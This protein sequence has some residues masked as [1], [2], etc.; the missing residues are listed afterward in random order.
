MPAICLDDIDVTA[1]LAR[2]PTRP[3]DHAVE[4]QALVELSQH[5]AETPH[6][7]LQALVDVALRICRAGS[8]GISILEEEDGESIF[9]WR[10][11]AGAFAPYLGGAMPG[12]FSPCAT[13]LDRNAAQLMANPERYYPYIASISPYVT[14]ALLVP[15]HRGGA[16]IGTVWVL[17]HEDNQRFDAED[18][19]LLT[20]I[21][22]FASAAV[23][24][25]A[26][27]QANGA[28]NDELR[29]ARARLELALSAG[30]IATWTWDI[31][32]DCVVAD[33]SLKRF[34]TTS[35]PDAAFHSIEHY[36]SAIHPADRERVRAQVWQAV[37]T[38][39]DLHSEY[40]I[41]QTDGRVLSLDVRGR[42]E[43]NAAGKATFM[44]GVT[45]DVTEQRE[46][47]DKL[48]T[49][50]KFSRSIVESSSDCVKVFDLDGRLLT[51]NANG[52][53]LMEV[54]DVSLFVSRRWQDCWPE[55]SRSMIEAAIEAATHGRATS[56][57]GFC[58][59]AKGAE[60]WWD[61]AVTPIVNA[62]GEVERILAV[63][64]D[65]TAIKRTEALLSSQTLALKQADQRK[66]DFLAMLAHELRN[67]LTAISYAHT[68]MEAS[69]E[70]THLEHCKETIGRQTKHLSRLI[71]DLLDVSRITLGKTELRCE[72]IN[73]GPLLE[74]A[75]HTVSP[76]VAQRKHTIDVTIDS[77]ELWVNADP[78]RLE[79]IVV[80]LLHN[81]AKYSE[82]CGHIWLSAG[83]ESGQ[84]VIRVKDEG[85]G[86]LPEKL[87]EMFELFAQADRSSARS[88]GGLG[89]GLTLAKRLVEMHDGAIA[90]H[91]DGSGKG[92]EFTIRL[93][94]ASRPSAPT[95][96]RNTADGPAKTACILVVDD[97]ADTAVTMARIL[98]RSGHQVVTAQ[99]GPEAIEAADEHQPDVILLDIGLPGMD[100]YEIVKRL[101]QKESTTKALIIAVTGYSQDG[102]PSRTR[103]A[104]F[105]HHLVK[106]IDLDHLKSLLERSP[107]G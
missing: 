99:S 43:R 80:N 89:I 93:P 61:V 53:R 62:D 21:S 6:T 17:L 36:L 72:L 95:S 47:A 27:L 103:V 23:Q 75:V 44:H 82:D 97:N 52:C 2:R 16:P 1:E 51:M 12:H 66:N 4:C 57:Q 74:S 49:S 60:K 88:A 76:L 77:D 42:I 106:P 79:Q 59:T 13:V 67:P 87:P 38:L 91:S 33:A 39:T 100:G 84:I 3:P 86:I 29:D 25:L 56:F 7:L 19:R 55:Q 26:N 92:S 24:M 63:L 71:D 101:R 28:A 104:G 35:S 90:A 48:I 50:E 54:D 70:P 83:R 11:T 8:A 46:A 85:V 20:S 32:D 5:L 41:V 31:I 102:D 68:L 105:D 40:R 30:E 15:F 9:R 14:E 73:A 45:V 22:K 10:A 81:A 78:T 18:A 96:L 107:R 34:F 94:A 64:R 69:N 58:P 98:K 37:E 65:I